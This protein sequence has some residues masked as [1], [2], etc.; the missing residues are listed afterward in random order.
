[1]HVRVCLYQRDFPFINTHR[2]INLRLSHC[3]IQ[4]AH[5]A[6][7]H[8]RHK[9]KALESS[10]K[11]NVI[12]S[13]IRTRTYGTSLSG[14]KAAIEDIKTKNH[15]QNQGIAIKSGKKNSKKMETLTSSQATFT[16]IDINFTE[17]AESLNSDYVDESNGRSDKREED[18]D[19]NDDDGDEGEDRVRDA[20][21]S[22]SS[23]SLG[24]EALNDLYLA[25][26][27]GTVMLV[28]TQSDITPLVMLLSKKQR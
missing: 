6:G 21:V 13:T 5:D 26:D 11:E 27:I 19:E 14:V 24:D 9:I 12:E 7:L 22:S 20:Y 18:V 23:F 17:K 25:S 28:L 15:D 8:F 10:Q 16:W 3:Y 4:D 1:M 2:I